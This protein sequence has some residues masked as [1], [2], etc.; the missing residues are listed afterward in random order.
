MRG[1]HR[2]LARPMRP[3]ALEIRLGMTLRS[4]FVR[5]AMLNPARFTHEKEE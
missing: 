5:W 4:S 3:V 2:C 1:Y